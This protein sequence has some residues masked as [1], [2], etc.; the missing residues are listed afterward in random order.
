[1][2]K[3]LLDIYSGVACA[4]LCPTEKPKLP[5]TISFCLEAVKSVM[6]LAVPGP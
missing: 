1:M 3:K 6:T 5:K 2:A 4:G